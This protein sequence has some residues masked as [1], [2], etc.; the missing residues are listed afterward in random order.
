MILASQ[1]LLPPLLFAS[2]LVGDSVSILQ[3]ALNIIKKKISDTG[4]YPRLNGNVNLSKDR[5]L[6][7]HSVLQPDYQLQLLGCNWQ[8]PNEACVVADKSNEL[9]CLIKH[10]PVFRAGEPKA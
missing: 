10:L 4:V 1:N 9:K 7:A 5:D 3:P 2:G 6:C 8:F